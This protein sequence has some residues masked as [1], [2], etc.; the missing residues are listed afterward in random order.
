[1]DTIKITL[2]NAYLPAVM[3][4]FVTVADIS[5]PDSISAAIDECCEIFANIHEAEIAEVDVDLDTFF[6][7]FGYCV[8]EVRNEF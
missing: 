4:E 1:M 6:E 8:E 5:D 2:A 3:E 7:M